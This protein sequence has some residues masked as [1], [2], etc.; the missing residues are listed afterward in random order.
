[1]RLS[2]P[3][4][5][6]AARNLG[7]KAILYADAITGSMQRAIEESNRRREVQ[8]AFNKQ[9]NITPSGVQKR[10][11]DVMEGAYAVPGSKLRVRHRG[12][13]EKAG[14]YGQLDFTEPGQLTEQIARLEALMYEQAKNLAFEE[15][16]ATRDKLAELKNQLLKQ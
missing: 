6:R 10:V 3:S 7:G 2:P 8:V 15:A 16:A 9:H 1:M 4:I 11:L 13:T 14:A 12:V 5:G